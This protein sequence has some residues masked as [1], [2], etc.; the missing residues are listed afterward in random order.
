MEA[1]KNN[2]SSFRSLITDSLDY[3]EASIVFSNEILNSPKNLK[4]VDEDEVII[5]D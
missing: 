3:S 4:Q 1:S 2:F 5:D